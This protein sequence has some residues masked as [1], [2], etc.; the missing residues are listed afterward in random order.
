VIALNVCISGF[1]Q[2][3]GQG[4]GVFRLS[5]SLMEAGHNQGAHRRVWYLPWNADWKKFARHVELIEALHNEKVLIAVH[6]YSWGG[7]WGAVQFCRQCRRRGLAV[8]YLVLCDPVYRSRLVSFRWRSLLPRDLLVFAAPTI[9]I[10][11]NVGEV[12]C[13]HQT[14]SRPAGHRV[15]ADDDQQTLIHQSVPLER[16]HTAMDHAVEFHQ[17]AHA[18]AE[19]LA[20]DAETSAVSGR[21]A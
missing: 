16:E 21:C 1:T 3:P 4:H 17:R 18:V 15:I 6:G 14:M 19:Q 13:F 5:E 11:P 7:G 10:P 12:W 8:R 20:L 9:R 2:G